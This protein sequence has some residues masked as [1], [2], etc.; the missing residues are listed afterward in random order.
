MKKKKIYKSPLNSLTDEELSELMAWGESESYKII[1]GVIDT[2]E[3]VRVREL[4]A[5]KQELISSDLLEARGMYRQAKSFLRFP[6]RA[7]VVLT[8]RKE[9]EK[10]KI[11]GRKGI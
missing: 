2:G 11:K 3:L 4:L 9:D 1:E 6:E 7:N 8:K 10:R 5:G